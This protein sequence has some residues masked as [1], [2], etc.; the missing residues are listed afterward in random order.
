MSAGQH[1]AATMSVRTCGAVVEHAE[2]L[3]GRLALESRPEIDLQRGDT[4]QTSL[5]NRTA[6]RV[7]TKRG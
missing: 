6:T 2:L 7:F 4:K 1:T 3:E 5:G